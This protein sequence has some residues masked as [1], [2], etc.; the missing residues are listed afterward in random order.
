MGLDLLPD[1][2]NTMSF[3]EQILSP[4]FIYSMWLQKNKIDYYFSSNENSV[5]KN[6]DSDD[7]VNMYLL[8]TKRITFTSKLIQHP[9]LLR[10]IYKDNTPII[11]TPISNP[12]LQNAETIYHS[13]P[14]NVL[15]NFNMPLIISS[16]YPAIWKTTPLTMDYYMLIMRLGDS[17]VDLHIL[18][19]LL[20]NSLVYSKISDSAKIT[21]ISQWNILWSQ[22]IC[23]LQGIPF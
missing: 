16:E 14:A 17:S 21:A 15:F 10:K 18:K 7:I 3:S 20:Y 13:N 11:L 8:G 1:I 5:L 12:L 4:D 23:K 2:D 19:Q 6:E 9:Y 22:W